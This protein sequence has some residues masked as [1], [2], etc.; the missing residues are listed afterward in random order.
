MPVVSDIQ[1][2]QGDAIKTLG[3]GGSTVWEKT[4]NTG[5]R[6]SGGKAVLMF[7]VKGLTE[8]ESDVDIKIK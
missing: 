4:F 6:Y 8:T 1:V 2:I 5:G 3:D 7:M